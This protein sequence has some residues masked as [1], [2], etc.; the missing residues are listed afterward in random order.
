MFIDIAKNFMK[1]SFASFTKYMNNKNC[2]YT[3]LMNQEH[4]P[5][6]LLQHTILIL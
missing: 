2:I 6:A 1:I 3:D 5:Y 4:I